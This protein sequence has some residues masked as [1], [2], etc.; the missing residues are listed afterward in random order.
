MLLAHWPAPRPSLFFYSTCS[1]CLPPKNSGQLHRLPT[2]RGLP[3]YLKPRCQTSLTNIEH[4]PAACSLQAHTRGTAELIKATKVRAT[5]TLHLCRGSTERLYSVPNIHSASPCPLHAPILLSYCTPVGRPSRLT[6]FPHPPC[7]QSLRMLPERDQGTQNVRPPPRSYGLRRTYSNTRLIDHLLSP[8][9]TPPFHAPHRIVAIVSGQPPPS[10][11]SS[12]L[13]PLFS[14][15][16][17][18]TASV[19]LFSLASSQFA[20]SKIAFDC[21][22][23]L[24]YSQSNLTYQPLPCTSLSKKNAVAPNR[25]AHC[26]PSHC[27]LKVSGKPTTPLI[28]CSLVRGTQ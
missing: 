11:A 14:L 16:S 5:S 24:P 4:Q 9:H 20:S 13:L 12:R 3:R 22:E 25:T 6:P 1:L 7:P 18:N 23:L 26:S 2:Y 15:R 17:H 27:I 8:F 28:Q 10:V 19:L 21:C